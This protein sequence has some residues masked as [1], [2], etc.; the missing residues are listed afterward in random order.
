MH[1]TT[2]LAYNLKSCESQQQLF[3]T[4]ITELDGG[5]GIVAAALYLFHFTDTEAVVLYELS[6]L[7]RCSGTTT[8]SCRWC[9]TRH[10]F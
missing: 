8:A 6:H 1:T 5:F 2:F 9:H 10:T 7:E 3:G 4:G